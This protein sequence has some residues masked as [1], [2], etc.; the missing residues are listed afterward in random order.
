MARQRRLI[1]TCALLALATL[2]GSFAGAQKGYTFRD[3]GTLGGD[4]SV[5]YAVN[6]G[7]QVVGG[8]TPAGS[9][10]YNVFLWLPA[11]AYGLPAGMNNLGSLGSSIAYGINDSGETVG[12]GSAAFV[13]LPVAGYGLPAGLSNL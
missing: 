4:S 6:N 10:N 5:G 7:G 9:G 13:W 11:A 1:T 12:Y 8:F 2:I 3:L